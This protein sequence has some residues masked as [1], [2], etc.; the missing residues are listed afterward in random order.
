MKMQLGISDELL[1]KRHQH[2]LTQDQRKIISDLEAD[3][4]QT[5]ERTKLL[6]LINA[7]INDANS[8]GI[9][10]DGEPD[11]IIARLKRLD[12]GDGLWEDCTT[13]FI[14]AQLK[15]HAYPS[16]GTRKT[17]LTRINKIDDN[18]WLERE[19]QVKP[20]AS[21]VQKKGG[22][23]VRQVVPSFKQFTL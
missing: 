10:T 5:K 23:W 21:W 20:G 14:R 1:L 12:S 15:S 6:K 11:D 2:F 18:E 4:R 13:E 9:K 7:L 19:S 17:L 16:K 8:Q 22:E 3:V